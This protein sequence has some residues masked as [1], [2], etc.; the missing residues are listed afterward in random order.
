MFKDKYLTNLLIETKN[1]NERHLNR[2][3]LK[4]KPIER[5]T[6]YLSKI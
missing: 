5:K 4:N 3:R 2:R 6:K 1:I